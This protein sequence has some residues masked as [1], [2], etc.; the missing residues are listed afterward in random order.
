LKDLAGVRVLAF[1]HKRLKEIDV[2]LQEPFGTWTPDPVLS[3][4]GEQ[5]ALK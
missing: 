4:E 5:L 3:E 2:E 1:P